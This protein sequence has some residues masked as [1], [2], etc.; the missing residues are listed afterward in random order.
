MTPT[1]TIKIASFEF[2]VCCRK[3]GSPRPLAAGDWPLPAA[4]FEAGA[5]A[6]H[7][8]HGGA[9]SLRDATWAASVY[10]PVAGYYWEPMDKAT[11]ARLA[12]DAKERAR[13]ARDGYP[14]D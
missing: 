7:A 9:K 3:I 6:H 1:V 13:A 4:D 2:P 8:K 5:N 12:Q 10:R 14:M 11:Q